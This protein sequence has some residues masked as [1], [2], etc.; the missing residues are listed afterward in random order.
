MTTRFRVVGSAFAAAALA[1]ATVVL[2]SGSVATL[3]DPPSGGA[4]CGGIA[5]LPCPQGCVCVDDPHDDCNPKRGG[6]DCIGICRPAP[7]SP[8]NQDCS[9]GASESFT[10]G[11]F[12]YCDPTKE[13]GVGENLA[14]SVSYTCAKDG[15]WLCINL[16]GT[17]TQ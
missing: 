10:E 9:G 13:P 12:A 5:G 15:T 4:A 6:A 2:L 3:A 16:D 14:C 7:G 1:I 17:P 11:S 8:S